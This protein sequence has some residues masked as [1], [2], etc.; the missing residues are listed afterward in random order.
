M[1]PLATLKINSVD[2]TLTTPNLTSPL[3]PA[4]HSVTELT[5]PLLA[6]ATSANTT[7]GCTIFSRRE[8]KTVKVYWFSVFSSELN[9]LEKENGEA[10]L[11]KLLS[12]ARD[13]SVLEFHP[14]ISMIMVSLLGYRKQ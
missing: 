4:S 1:E 12:L 2:S 14:C 7:T 13:S 5:A 8:K 9:I 3:A 10:R 11:S 6:P